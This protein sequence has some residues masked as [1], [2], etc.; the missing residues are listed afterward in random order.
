MSTVNQE[1][2]LEEGVYTNTGGATTAADPLEHFWSQSELTFD[3]DC[4]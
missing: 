1:S 4:L 3:I 2:T